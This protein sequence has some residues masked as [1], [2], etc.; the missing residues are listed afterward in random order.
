M[1][2]E[3]KPEEKKDAPAA[4]PAPAAPVAAAPVAAAPP[5]PA[6]PPPGPKF[7]PIVP[8]VFQP[9]RSKVDQGERA[10]DGARPLH[11]DREWIGYAQQGG[12]SVPADWSWGHSPKQEQD[13][14]M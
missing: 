10:A 6:G 13:E 9:D 4:A 11:A 1:S 12:G 5:K 7:P 14:T 3:K 8:L 2:D